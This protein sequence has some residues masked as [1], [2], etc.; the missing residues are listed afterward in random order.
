MKH[1]KQPNVAVPGEGEQIPVDENL[2][3]PFRRK[4][5]P[6]VKQTLRRRRRR[7]LRRNFKLSKRS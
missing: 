1:K 2:P 4:K 3:N 6:V 7:N 5:K